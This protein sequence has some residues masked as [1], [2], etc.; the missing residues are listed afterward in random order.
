[1]GKVSK[2]TYENRVRATDFIVGHDKNG[3]VKRFKGNF[4]LRDLA[5]DSAYL[6]MLEDEIEARI[7]GDA[8]LDDKIDLTRINLEALIT[9]LEG[10]ITTIQGDLLTI[11]GQIQGL[12]TQFNNALYGPGGIVESYTSLINNTEASLKDY[13]DQADAALTVDYDGKIQGLAASI[14]LGLFVN[15]SLSIDQ[16][17]ARFNSSPSTA[18]FRGSYINI[19]SNVTFAEGYDPFEKSRVFKF[20][21]PHP[22]Y[23]IDDLRISSGGDLFV[24]NTKRTTGQ[25]YVGSDWTLALRY[26]GMYELNSALTGYA[27]EQ[28][29][30]DNFSTGG[31]GVNPEDWFSLIK[32]DPDNSATW[33]VQTNYS[34]T[35]VKEIQ[36]WTN[37][38]GLPP[39]WLGNIAMATETALG[40]IKAYSTYVNGIRI[41][42]NGFL[43]IDP[44][45]SGG[46]DVSWGDILNKPTTFPST[47]AL[48]SGLQTALDNKQDL[49][50]EVVYPTSGDPYIKTSMSLVSEKEI[51]AWTN[52][53]QLPGTIWDTIPDATTTSK[54]VVQIGAGINVSNGVIS[55]DQSTI[56]PQTLSLSGNDL[57]I[58]NGNTVDLGTILP[59][60]SWANITGKPETA[61]RWP[62]WGEVTGKPALP[63]NNAA[64][65]N[66]FFT[67]YNATTGDFTK[68]QPT[69]ANVSGLQSALDLKLDESAFDGLFEL[70]TTGTGSYIRAKYALASDYEITA[71]ADSGQDLPSI[72]DNLPKASTSAYGVVR[73]GS[74]INVVDGV[75]SVSGT[76][77]NPNLSFSNNILSVNASTVD[78][79]SLETDLT[80]YATETWVGT[81]YHPIGGSSTLNMSVNNLTIYGVVNQ[82][83]AES[84]VVEDAR[85]Q[86]N[87]TQGAAIVSAGIDIFNGTSV[88]SSLLYTHDTSR[89]QI[90]GQNIATEAWVTTGLNTKANNTISIIA[91]NGLTGGGT[92]AASRTLTMGTPSTISA[93]STNSVTATSHTHEISFYGSPSIA[94][95][96]S[97]PDLWP[98]GVTIHSIGSNDSTYPL[99]YGTV[100]NARAGNMRMLQLFQSHQSN[101]LWNRFLYSGVG[102]GTWS[103]IYN[104]DYH[105]DADKLGG[106]NSSD[107]VRRTV[108][109]TITAGHTFA[110]GLTIG[111]STG[112]YNQYSN[113][114]FIRDFNNGAVSYNGAGGDVYLGYRRTE[115]IR[116]L[117]GSV[118]GQGTEKMILTGAGFLGLNVATPSERL[119][120]AG[121]A[122]FEGGG[123]IQDW[124]SGNLMKIQNSSWAVNHF[125]GIEFWNGAKSNKPLAT[126]KM[127]IQMPGGGD[128]GDNIIFQ[129]QRRQGVNPNITVP[130]TILTL[131]DEGNAIFSGSGTFGGNVTASGEVT[132]YSS[133][134]SRLKQNIKPITSALDLIEGLNPVSYNWN[135]KAIALNSIKDNVRTNYGVIAQEIEK[136]L[137]D[138]VHQTNGYKSVDYIQM[139]GILLAGVREL[140]KEVNQLKQ[141][142]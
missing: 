35:S 64:T 13:I 118:T 69:I 142:V 53:G 15:G 55:L 76:A 111:G 129:N 16:L 96:I 131:N 114:W 78:L 11:D 54:G 9:G 47:I 33:Y 77:L 94:G 123:I 125:T 29:V 102:T 43:E 110:A 107:W 38:G 7:A 59:D 108:A 74:N 56:T 127:I 72:F 51:Q 28:W 37:A 80:G 46:G 26:I 24:A 71:F 135:K 42:I 36:A 134:D 41:N 91:G 31:G 66:Q 84:L 112:I 90:G 30:T 121:N 89:W 120:V 2:Y 27:T 5:N 119:H 6:A 60:L 52:N 25:A 4:F 70:V 87:R 86:V 95:N 132:A 82:W 138:L 34:L 21:P 65:A 104:D 73:I 40:G 117:T 10:D 83:L 8:L 58:S 98:N 103:R 133:S 137:P 100:L 109:Q 62:A 92:L 85:I 49:L 44:T 122:R 1:M 81:N 105:P 116:F 88:V 124:T 101:A 139:I 17:M 3:N 23:E 63:I 141:G 32:P 68:A 106:V 18:Q 128:R 75:I 12:A 20:T 22:P 50:F 14:D 61:T 130:Q 67:A 19:N 97:N 79:S 115:N 113:D 48:V 39:S 126:S 57:S 93:S 45:Y 136:V 99:G 140:R